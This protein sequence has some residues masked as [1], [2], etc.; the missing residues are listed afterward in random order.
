MV[1]GGYFA[2]LA[3]VFTLSEWNESNALVFTLSEWNESKCAR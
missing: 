3:L 2:S 1:E